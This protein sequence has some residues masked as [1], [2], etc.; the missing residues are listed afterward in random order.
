MKK[1]MSY[2]SVL[3]L[4]LAACD[5]GSGRD[6]SPGGSGNNNIQKNTG[7][8]TDWQT[9]TL[10]QEGHGGDAI[11]CFNIPVERALYKIDTN[12]DFGCAPGDT[13]SSGNS[14]VS[15]SKPGSSSSGVVWRM[16]NEGRGS[17]QS[18]KPLEQYIAERIA[19]K[20]VIIDQ[21]NQMSL[22]EGYKRVIRPFAKLPA[23]F[24]RISEIHRKLG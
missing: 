7:E 4:F 19:S 1:F 8:V 13:C 16:T 18:A 3:C 9:S 2:L 21:L 5:Q 23:P 15:P 24:N 11:V 10:G 12:P 6:K 20:K 17:I 22:E 14:S